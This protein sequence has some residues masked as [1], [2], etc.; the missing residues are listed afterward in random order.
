MSNTKTQMVK[1]AF[2]F[3][4][5]TYFSQIVGMITALLI[6]KYLGPERMGIWAVMLTIFGYTTYSHLG[7]LLAAEKE[8]PY[9][10]GKND[11]PTA[12]R[13]TNVSFSFGTIFSFLVAALLVIYVAI[14]H[15]R[16]SLE[17]QIGLITV[18]LLTLSQWGINYVVTILKSNNE[19]KVLT[20]TQNWNITYG[21]IMTIG[22]GF[23]W[24]IY[25]IYLAIVLSTSIWLVRLLTIRRYHVSFDFDWAYLWK[26]L[27]I[28]FPLLLNG[29]AFVSL[30]TID[31]IVIGRFLGLKELGIYSL[32]I[33]ISSSLWRLPNTFGIVLFPRMQAKFGKEQAQADALVNFILL[34]TYVITYLMPLLFIFI[35]IW[36]PIIIMSFLPNYLAG[37]AAMQIMLLGVFF[38]SLS[39]TPTQYFITVNRPY[40]LLVF[41]YATILASYGL[42]WALVRAGYGISGVAV[43]M[44]ITYLFYGLGT[45]LWALSKN[46]KTNKLPAILGKILLP[47]IYYLIILYILDMLF[48]GSLTA[49]PLFAQ[50]LLKSAIWAIVSLPMA[51]LCDKETKVV[52]HLFA[53]FKA[54][55]KYIWGNRE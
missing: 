43:G 21:A 45:L 41:T 9:N 13:I 40:A 8:L 38:L 47:V 29:L 11:M 52:T 31:R 48:S 37:M 14:N 51:Y 10:Y 15:A 26:L 46:I 4:V 44:T 54:K 39:V 34:P 16:F 20:G 18:A 22:F 35:Y 7:T 33:M 32:A 2:R 6:R 17:Y 28:G 19:F 24:N 30:L 5:T 55:L 36:F 53:I 42:N 49:F 23:L 25:G 27:F 3:S 12:Q 50:G 1:D